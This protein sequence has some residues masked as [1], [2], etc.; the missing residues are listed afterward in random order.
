MWLGTETAAG[1]VLSPLRQVCSPSASPLC[2]DHRAVLIPPGVSF[3]M[4]QE[5]R[6]TASLSYPVILPQSNCAWGGSH[7]SQSQPWKESL[8]AACVSCPARSSGQGIASPSA[9]PPRQRE[10]RK[11]RQKTTGEQGRMRRSLQSRFRQKR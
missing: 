10:G 7:R 1:V 8:S 5:L 3:E 9:F 11:E 4:W 2:G 6:E